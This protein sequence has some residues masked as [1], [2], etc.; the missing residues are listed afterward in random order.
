MYAFKKKLDK[1]I[2]EYPDIPY[3][4]R[5]N[6]YLSKYVNVKNLFLYEGLLELN[7]GMCSNLLYLPNLP[8]SLQILKCEFAKY[9][10]L[11]T[12][13]NS[14]LELDV[15]HSK[16]TYLPKLPDSLLK[17]NASYSKITWYPTFPKNLKVL[18]FVSDYIILKDLPDSL[19]ELSCKEAKNLPKNLL[20]LTFS[21]SSTYIPELPNTLEYLDCRCSKIEIIPKLSDNIVYFDCSNSKI[22]YLPSLPKNLKFLFCYETNITYIPNLPDELEELNCSFTKIKEIPKLPNSLKELYCTNN[23]ISEIPNI[24]INLYHLN[25]TTTNITKLPKIECYNRFVFLYFAATNVDKIPEIGDKFKAI[26]LHDSCY[27][28]L[29]HINYELNNLILSSDITNFEKLSDNIEE[30]FFDNNTNISFLPE[31]PNKLIKLSCINTK[32]KKIPKLPDT[33]QELFTDSTC[34][35][36]LPILPNSLLKLNCHRCNIKIL[37]NLPNNLIELDCSYNPIIEIPFLPNTL[38]KINIIYTKIKYIPN[39]IMNCF[40]L[41][42]IWYDGCPIEYNNPA[43]LRFI[44]NRKTKSNSIYNDNQ[45]VHN[46]SIQLSVKES[47]DKIL[48]IKPVI[49]DIKEYINMNKIL[50]NTSLLEFCNDKTIH[51]LLNITFEEAL[52]SVINEIER[53]ENKEEILKILVQEMKDS[54]SKCFTGRISRLIN[55]LNGYSNNVSINISENEQISNIIILLKSKFSGEELKNKIKERLKE[56]KITDNIIELWISELD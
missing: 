48:S 8:S 50:E 33:L 40:N 42:N 9:S 4:K 7:V 44:N 11:P 32:L 19:L 27:V 55:C 54:E 35:D 17:L 1:K 15:N 31:L 18:D 46:S 53:N 37:P 36:E 10:Y 52:I 21:K 56:L 25:C 23:N 38:E 14:L 29:T 24:P 49:I 20:K 3:D 2:Y 34:L 28:N 41:N 47:Y 5:I 6:L 39:S 26:H 13:P 12:L 45:S 51:S 43:I 16:L 30:L 22:E